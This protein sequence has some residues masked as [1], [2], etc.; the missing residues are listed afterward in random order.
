MLAGAKA[1]VA[2]VGRVGIASAVGGASIPFLHHLRRGRRLCLRA[3]LMVLKRNPVRGCFPS[4]C[5]SG[6]SLIYGIIT[7]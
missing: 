7:L 3:Q 4:R 2:G 1:G 6:S 5:S